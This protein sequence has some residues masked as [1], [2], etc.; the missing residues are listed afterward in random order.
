MYLECLWLKRRIGHS[1][2]VVRSQVSDSSAESMLDCSIQCLDF[3]YVHAS[4]SGVI[5]LTLPF[6]LEPRL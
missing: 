3:L 2:V 1:V 4:G 6:T 5:Y